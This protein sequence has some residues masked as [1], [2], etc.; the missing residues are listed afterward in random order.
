MARGKG[1]Q[2]L[3][4]IARLAARRIIDCETLGEYVQ[5]SESPLIVRGSSGFPPA[6][7]V[8]ATFSLRVPLPRRFGSKFDPASRPASTPTLLKTG[9]R[10]RL[11]KPR[12]SN[13]TPKTKPRKVTNYLPVRRTKESQSTPTKEATTCL[14][15]RLQRQAPE[16]QEAH[17]KLEQ[18]R[19]RRARG[20]GLCR[21]CNAKAIPG[22]I[23]CEPCAEKHRESHRRRNAA[24]KKASQELNNQE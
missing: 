2:A 20:L 15:R 14:D 8:G 17:R 16:R 5:S 10:Q 4:S 3:S 1:Q 7:V 23:R 24:K 22:Q 21:D 11:T 12:S 6:R 13:P 9:D 18:E 19:R